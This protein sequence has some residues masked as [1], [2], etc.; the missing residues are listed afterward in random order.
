MATQSKYTVSW[1]EGTMHPSAACE[2]CDWKMG[3]SR[4]TTA[5]ACKAHVANTGHKVERIRQTIGRYY[6]R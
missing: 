2:D 4:L 5:A 6:P 1:I 3:P